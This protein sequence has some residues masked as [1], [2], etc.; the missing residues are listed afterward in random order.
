MK[1]EV[2]RTGGSSYISIYIYITH[3]LHCNF[4]GEKRHGCVFGWGCR[5][6]ALLR[7]EW[8]IV[9]VC[10]CVTFFQNKFPRVNGP[11]RI[12]PGQ[13]AKET[14]SVILDALVSR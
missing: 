8:T 6:G 3:V 4:L 7:E 11:V 1:T 14:E 12:R 10:M 13:Q 2:G 9:A 5:L